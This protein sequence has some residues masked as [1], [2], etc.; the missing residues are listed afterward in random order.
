MDF[1]LSAFFQGPILYHERYF[2]NTRNPKFKQRVARYSNR[3]N[4]NRIRFAR[5]AMT[6]IIVCKSRV[7]VFN[8]V[9][10]SSI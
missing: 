7:I 1:E 5:S 3:D 2:L 10:L 4:L 9:G 6:R 8:W